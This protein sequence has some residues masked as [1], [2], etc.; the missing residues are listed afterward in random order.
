MPRILQTSAPDSI[1]KAVYF[2]FSR[3]DLPS[4]ARTRVVG[5]QIAG[6]HIKGANKSGEP[7]SPVIIANV[8]YPNI[9]TAGMFMLWRYFEVYAPRY[10][11]AHYADARRP[12]WQRHP[13]NPS[14]KASPAT[15]NEPP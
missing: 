4:G 5:E 11:S 8:P 12:D 3:A 7:C 6:E 13:P 2:V 9:H 1:N 15:L 10:D 14:S